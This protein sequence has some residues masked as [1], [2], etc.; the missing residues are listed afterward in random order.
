MFISGSLVELYKYQNPIVINRASRIHYIKPVGRSRRANDK[1]RGKNRAVTLQRARRNI[2]HIIH[3]NAGKWIDLRGKPYSPV[4]MTLTYA[5]NMTD[6]TKGYR[7][8]RKFIQRLNYHLFKDKKSHFKY[9]TVPEFQE[10]GSLHYHSI[11]FNL[12]YIPIDDLL[13]IWKHGS[14]EIGAVDDLERSSQ[15]MTKTLRPEKQDERLIGQKCYLKSQGLYKAKET[16]DKRRIE[17]YTSTLP[18]KRTF[19]VEFANAQYGTIKYE[20]FKR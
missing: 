18:D 19:E 4:V 9:V 16:T 15:Y 10:R 6:I 12:P 2:K 14:V 20:R 11:F 13:Q 17:S 8:Y 3:A 7:D 1:D 5:E